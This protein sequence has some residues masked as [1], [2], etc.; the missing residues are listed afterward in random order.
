MVNDISN[1]I[2]L[3]FNSIMHTFDR[4]QYSLGNTKVDDILRPGITMVMKGIPSFSRIKHLNDAGWNMEY[5][6]SPIDKTGKFYITVPLSIMFGFMEDYKGYIYRMPQKLT[7]TR[8]SASHALNLILAKDDSH[9]I[10]VTF[11]DIVWRMPLIRFNLLYD[12]K[13]KAEILKGSEYEIGFRHWQYSY[14]SGIAGSKE[15]TWDFPT[16]YSRA[17]YV[18]IAFQTDRENK[19]TQDLSKF[20]FCDIRSVQV[21]LNDSHMYPRE[22]PLWNKSE[23]RFGSLYTMFKDFK[24]SYYSTD[25]HQSEPL[26]NMIDFMKDYPIICIDTSRRPDV[27]KDSLINIKIRMEFGTNLPEKTIIHCVIISDSIVK[28]NPLH[29]IAIA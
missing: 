20:D 8:N 15:C 19:A 6:E 7:F 10:D 1:I 4:I 9:D 11:K 14:K 18:L 16:A 12:A 26:I 29:N 24:L 23:L 3:V 25:D 22:R 21:V 17:K 5:K 27:I 2:Q 13:I 28:Y